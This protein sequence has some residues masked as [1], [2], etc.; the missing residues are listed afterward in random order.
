MSGLFNQLRRLNESAQR[1]PAPFSYEFQIQQKSTRFSK[2]ISLELS[3]SFRN[4][5]KLHTA[6]VAD[7]ESATAF[8]YL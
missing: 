2:K 7:V 4:T 1:S 5:P 8:P 6:Q 3:L